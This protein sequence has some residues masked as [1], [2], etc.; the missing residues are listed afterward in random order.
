MTQSE[1]KWGQRPLS[2]HSHGRYE[3]SC[4][5]DAW[6]P[7]RECEEGLKSRTSS[8]VKN[9]MRTDQVGH[10]PSIMRAAGSDKGDSIFSKK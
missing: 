4:R 7:L 10:E 6:K 3:R 2:A 1:G 5:R 9:D 8:G